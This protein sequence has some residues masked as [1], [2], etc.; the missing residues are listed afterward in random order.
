MVVVGGGSCRN[1]RSGV[2]VVVVVVYSGCRRSYSGGSSY[3]LAYVATSEVGSANVSII[4]ENAKPLTS[5][6]VYGLDSGNTFTISTVTDHRSG[7]TRGVS[8]STIRLAAD[9]PSVNIS[10]NTITLIHKVGSNDGV[11]AQFV[12]SS[13]DTSTKIATVTLPTQLALY[14]YLVFEWIYSIGTNRTNKIGQAGGMFYLPEATFRSGERNF[15]LTE[16]F[17]NS[18][19]PDSISF[20]DKTYN[21]SGLLVN[22]TNLVDTVLSVG[23]NTQIV[24]S[25]TADRLLSSAA[26][27]AVTLA[28]WTIPQ[29]PPAP[30]VDNWEGGWGGRGTGD[31][32]SQTFFVDP[33]IYPY[34]LFLSSVDLF[35][36]SKATEDF[37]VSVQ[38]RPTVNG[39]PSS[40]FWYP[41][42]SLS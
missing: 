5:K 33:T 16:S 12:I 23:I 25:Q 39:F 7:V 24:G 9:A 27:S 15:R 36:K 34:G 35:F 18:F 11:G 20:A 10:G 41:A 8:S 13:Y 6:F 21:S 28:S 4:N 37:P 3:D 40:D 22:K 30:P 31:P 29:P 17:N 38:I 26:A 32:L 19:N 1:C 2:V 14:P 42:E